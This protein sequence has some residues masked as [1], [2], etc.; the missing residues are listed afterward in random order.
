MEDLDLI[1][2]PAASLCLLEARLILLLGRGYQSAA[3][4][5][6]NASFPLLSQSTSNAVQISQRS[7]AST[8]VLSV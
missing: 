7:I 5:A 3:W 6:P 2:N 1:A 4:F 8:P